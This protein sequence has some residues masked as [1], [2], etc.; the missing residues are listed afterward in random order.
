MSM[1]LNDMLKQT[2]IYAE[3]IAFSVLYKVLF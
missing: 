2:N 3:N 1:E